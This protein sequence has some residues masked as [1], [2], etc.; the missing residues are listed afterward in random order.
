MILHHSINPVRAKTPASIAF[1]A[2][3]AVK[4]KT[5]NADT[6]ARIITSAQAE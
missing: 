4:D 5:L 6:T 3:M 1:T 2:A